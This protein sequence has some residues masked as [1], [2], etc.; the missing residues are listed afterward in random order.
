MNAFQFVYNIKNTKN[1]QEISNRNDLNKQNSAQIAA[2]H[3]VMSFFVYH[4][5]MVWF[6]VMFKGN[7]EKGQ[8]DR[9]IKGI[10]IS[11]CWNELIILTINP[12]ILCR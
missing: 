8:R 1:K 4:D 3:Q 11:I 9:F 2:L 6:F 12:L 5:V 7:R 10:Y